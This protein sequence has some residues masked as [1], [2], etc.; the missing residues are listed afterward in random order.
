VFGNTHGKI[1]FGATL[2]TA[3]GI[4][5][6]A[7][8]AEG[9]GYDYLVAGEHMMFHGP[10]SNSIIGIS[11]A[12]GATTRIMRT[13]VRAVAGPLTHW[14]ARSTPAARPGVFP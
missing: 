6:F 3:K 8:R 13:V 12:A 10:I 4:P 7:R 1:E 11:I 9:L 2:P 14:G 5:E